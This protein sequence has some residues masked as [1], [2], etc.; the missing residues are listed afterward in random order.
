MKPGDR[1]IAALIGDHTLGETFKE[2]LLHV[3][4]V[5]W[6]ESSVSSEKLAA[7]L[8][9]VYRGIRPF[10]VTLGSEARIGYEGKAL[11]NLVQMP[12]PFSDIYQR[13]E[14]AL[15]GIHAKQLVSGW[16]DEYQ[17]HVT[18]QRSARLQAND[19]FLVDRLYIISQQGS[20]KRIEAE[21][22]LHA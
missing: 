21:V 11:V 18:V 2:W 6:F 1:L 10:T 12:T 7:L 3:T 14:Q 22:P 20:F 17:P 9:G 19:T 15:E 16:S 13:T 5:P 8:A 4:I